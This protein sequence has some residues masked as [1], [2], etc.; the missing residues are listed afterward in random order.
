MN[1]HATS[2]PTLGYT[3]LPCGTWRIV[4]I[5]RAGAPP[6]MVGPSF[7][8][9]V[10]LLDALPGFAARNFGYPMPAQLDAQTRDLV[11]RLTWNLRGL[12]AAEDV[13]REGN[14]PCERAVAMLC[15]EAQALIAE[16]DSL[17][18]GAGQARNTGVAQGKTPP[19]LWQRLWQ[20]L[21]TAA[22]H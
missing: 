12:C 14:Q 16:V 13:R 1:I 6:C 17:L 21:P 20:H 19:S 8:G 4:H 10:Q 7:T 15:E 5:T 2:Y 3:Q 22:R 9:R 11:S 18:H